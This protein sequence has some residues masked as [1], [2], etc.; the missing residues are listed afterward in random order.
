MKGGRKDR[1]VL[2]GASLVLAGAILALTAAAG[3][4]TVQH[5]WASPKDHHDC[6]V[7]HWTHGTGTS[8]PASGFVLSGPLLIIASLPV[9]SPHWTPQNVAQPP[10]SRAPPAVA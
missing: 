2:R 4:D 7:Y 1:R 3:P 8:A 10:P 6:A 5:L 9:H